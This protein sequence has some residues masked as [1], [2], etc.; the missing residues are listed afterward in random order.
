MAR[1]GMAQLL[2]DLRRETYAGT[3]D[4]TVAG[5]AYWTDDQLQAQ[6]DRTREDFFYRP[7][8]TQ[9]EL[10]SGGTLMSTETSM[11]FG[12]GLLI[13]VRSCSCLDRSWSTSWTIP[14]AIVP[15][16]WVS[17]VTLSPMRSG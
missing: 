12:S 3:A 11:A 4:H 9:P 14:S 13:T 17:S 7:L 1:E 6:L 10:S 15:K 2:L 16:D 8:A 5:V